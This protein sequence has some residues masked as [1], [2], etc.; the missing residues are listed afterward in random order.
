MSYIVESHKNKTNHEKNIQKITWG[1]YFPGSLC[2]QYEERFGS[3]KSL[4]AV[5]H[6]SEYPTLST[7]C[8]RRSW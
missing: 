2:S 4:K 6:A 3:S 5:L 8:A 7:D 1:P